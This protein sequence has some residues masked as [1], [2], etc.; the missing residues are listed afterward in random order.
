MSEGGVRFR[1]PAAMPL[2]GRVEVDIVADFARVEGLRAVVRR[3]R[4]E[5]HDGTTEVR[6][7][8]VDLSDAQR[9]G[10]IELMFTGQDA[11]TRQPIEPGHPMHSLMTI[12]LAPWIALWR[13][14]IVGD[15]EVEAPAK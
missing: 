10:V 4:V 1:L 5:E 2:E 11:W 9:R 3:W 12:V 6:V 14:L 8:F 15:E 13:A 7:A